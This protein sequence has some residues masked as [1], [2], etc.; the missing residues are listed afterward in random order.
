MFSPG[1]AAASAFFGGPITATYLIWSNF[2]TLGKREDASKTIWLGLL[3]TVVLFGI[4]YMLPEGAS[5][6]GMGIAQLIIAYSITEN[7]QVKKSEIGEGHP[8]CRKSHWL[9]AG[10]TLAGLVFTIVLIFVLAFLF[11]LILS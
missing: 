10:I 11:S 2:V 8:Y 9:V 6:V 5:G 3:A 4:A 7:Y 1:Q